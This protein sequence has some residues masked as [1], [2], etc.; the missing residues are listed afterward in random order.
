MKVA[1]QLGALWFTIIP[2]Y[3]MHLFITDLMEEKEKKLRIG[4]NIYGVPNKSYWNSWVLTAII[5][6]AITAVYT[7]LLNMIFEFEV[8][9]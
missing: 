9:L 6:S 8:W 2:L 3:I 4:M 1:N 7:I 5:I